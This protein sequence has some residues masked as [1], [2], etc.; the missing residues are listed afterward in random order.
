MNKVSVLHKGKSY[1][2]RTTLVNYILKQKINILVSLFKK[3]S[4]VQ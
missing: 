3:K 2:Q 4:Y 1:I